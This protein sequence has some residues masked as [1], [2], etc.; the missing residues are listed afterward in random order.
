VRKFCV[1]QWRRIEH[2]WRGCWTSAS[3]KSG[4]L[5]AAMF[6]LVLLALSPHLREAGLIEAPTTYW[7]IA[8]FTFVSAVASVILAFLI[9]FV[10]RWLLAPSRMYWEERS[11]N[12]IST[13]FLAA[14]HIYAES[15]WVKWK[16]GSDTGL[17]ETGFYLQIG[18]ALN[19]GKTLERVQARIFL[20]GE[21]LLARI[22]ETG[23]TE[24]DIRHG[25]LAF[26]QIGSLV[27][28]E[29]HGLI[30]GGVEIDDERRKTFEHNIPLGVLSFEVWTPTGKRAYGLGHLPANPGKFTLLVIVSANDVVARHIPITID[31]TKNDPVSYSL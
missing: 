29:M 6:W 24:I 22:K 19:N 20:T 26:F 8:G 5:G 14:D 21:P 16:D 17:Y 31:L 11:K 3:E 7:G 18:N 12:D 10:G 23:N 9:I 28:K 2:A 4:L 13:S 1:F 15:K 30:Q 25:E 27:S